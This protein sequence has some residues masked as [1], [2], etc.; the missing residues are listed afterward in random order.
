ML[1]AVTNAAF[2]GVE[3]SCDIPNDGGELRRFGGVV[4][5]RLVRRYLFPGVVG[6]PS[7]L[8]DFFSHCPDMPGK[9]EVLSTWG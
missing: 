7:I 3:F 8:G 6:I 5:H 9:C 2:L 4:F 1:T